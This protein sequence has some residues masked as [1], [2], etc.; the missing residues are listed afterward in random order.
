MPLAQM[1]TCPHCRCEFETWQQQA[2]CLAVCPSCSEVFV[3]PPP[4]ETTSCQLDT[5]SKSFPAIQVAPSRGP[6]S[7]R[8][9]RK[10]DSTTIMNVA[11]LFSG[12][13]VLL[14]ALVVTV[15]ESGNPP[16]SSLTPE[17][18]DRESYRPR[19]DRR[20]S[21]YQDHELDSAR[22]EL[23]RRGINGDDKAAEAILNLSRI[24]ESERGGR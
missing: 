23:R 22:A 7:R 10:L 2:E 19:E 14:C 3:R 6:H 21:Y 4:Q 9:R 12:A 18:T 15:A 20:S 8:R 13:T 24:M 17:V 16:P 5:L 1:M 11:F